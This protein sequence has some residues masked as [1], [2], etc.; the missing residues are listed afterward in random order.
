MATQQHP[1][2][3]PESALLN[4]SLLREGSRRKQQFVLEPVYDWALQVNQLRAHAHLEAESWKITE[5]ET[6]RSLQPKLEKARESMEERCRRLSSAAPTGNLRGDAKALVD[7]SEIVRES[8]QTVKQVLCDADEFPTVE[9][10]GW[11]RQPRAYAAVAS[12]LR[13]VNYE[14]DERSFEQYITAIQE[15]AVFE[16]AELWHLRPFAELVLLERAAEVAD[17]MDARTM[18]SVEGDLEAQPAT[19]AASMTTL[20]TS[21]RRIAGTD[22]KEVF[23]RVNAIERILREDPCHVYARMDFES[24]DTYR[25][26]I[27]E[28]A[29]RSRASEEEIARKALEFSRQLHVEADERV[30]ERKS[31]IGYH[32]VGDGR[33]RLENEIGYRRTLTERT[34]SLIKRCPDFTYMLAIELVTFAVVAAALLGAG[35]G[36]SG[37]AIVALFFLP[38][39]ECGVA[40]VNQLVTALFPPRILP[41]LDF[42]D[43][44]PREFAA[45]VAVPTL[46]TSEEQ[47]KKAVRDLEIRF[48]ANRDS[49]LHFALLTDPPDSGQ[50]FDEKDSLAEQC[51]HLIQE[52]NERYAREARGS[53]YLFHRHRAYNESEGVWMGWERKRGKLLDF[54]KLLLGTADNFPIKT[55]NLSILPEIKYVIPVDLDTQLPRD[56]ARKL[57]GA[58]AHPLNR[59]VINRATNTVVDGYGILQPRVDIS[60]QSA[61]RSRLAAIFSADA[62]FDIYA[63]AVSDVYQDL[64]GEG[65][66]TGKGIYEVKTFQQVLEHRFPCNAILSHDMIEGAYARAGLVSD[67]EVVDDYP[68][69]MSAYS[70]RKHRWVRGDWQIVFWLLPRV[71]NFFGKMEHN[72]LSIISRWKILD[73][74]RRSMTE[75]ATFVMLL[76]GWLF[77]PG[78]ALYWTLTTL[79]VV[80]LPTYSPFVLTIA[81]AKRALFTPAFWKNLAT[82][83]AIAQANLSMRI[84]C[85]CHQSLVSVDAIIRAVVRMTVTHERLLEWETAA[86]AEARS[87]KRSPFE[88]YLEITPWLAFFVGLFLAVD[89]AEA[90]MPALPLLVLWGLSKPIVQWLNLPARM[91]EDRM[92]AKDEALLRLSALRTWRLFREFSTAEENWLVPDTVQEPASLIVHRISTT[93]L[94]LLMNSRLAATDLGFF[95]LPE[96]LADTEKTLDTIDRMPKLN[97]QM[98]NWYDTLTLE[99][100]KPRF[101]SS[102]DNGN[103]VCCLW[104][105]K[106]GCLGAVNERVFSPELWRGVTDYLDAIEESLRT[107]RLAHPLLSV[108]KELKQKVKALGTSLTNWSEALPALERDVVVLDKRLS[109]D[110][111]SSEAGWWAHELCLRITHL[112][113]LV[114]DFVPWL[115]PQFARHCQDRE[116]QNIIHSER[117]SLESLPRIC[118]ALDQKLGRVL[119]VEDSELESRSAFQLLRSA[120]ARTSSICGSTTKRLERLA[121]RAD[122]LAK[123]L[124]FASMYDAQKKALSI[125][126]DVEQQRLAPYFYDLLPSEARAGAFVAIAKGEIPQDTWLSLERRYTEYEGERAMLSWTGTMFEYLMPM[127]W[128][129]T[130]PNT[131]LDEATQAAVRCQ[132]K[133]ADSK[134][135]PWG[136]SEASCSKLNCDGHYHYEAFGVP[137][138]AMNREMSMDLVVSPYSAFLALMADT[139]TAVENIRRMKDLGWMGSYGFYEAADFTPSRVKARERFEIVRCW[140]AHHQGMSLMAV[141]NVLCNGSSQRRFHA[142]PMVAASERL[143]HEKAPRMSQL[144]LPMITDGQ[145]PVADPNEQQLTAETWAAAASK[146]KPAA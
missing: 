13:A 2:F 30:C 71:P 28:L 7:G 96:F 109:E 32:L 67:V 29:K 52:L 139:K 113:N 47:M 135:M 76:S 73:N 88:T 61:N 122:A 20:M 114:Y 14:F 56:S 94:G 59:A 22:W 46:L 25:N 9:N 58:M 69:H 111:R 143:L 141:A 77:F 74:L 65:S 54:N 24:R 48:L 70:R 146:A 8:V 102:V 91:G 27:A 36:V 4:P 78:K 118:A 38:A 105:V 26:T 21:L 144:E 128:M 90:F 45:M 119:E 97:G 81:R 136:I 63:R 11:P 53:F 85:L 51:V 37:F 23:E 92:E 12:Y 120:L 112:E 107:E 140:L 34:R 16:M 80:A 133:Y 131:T 89:R 104:T 3:D 39:A 41:K 125:G 64:F 116:I 127:L 106:H 17:Q 142:E 33:K 35:V 101:V 18:E 75:T 145:P 138:L 100:V 44:I 86:E 137:A 5:R 43:G 115:A 50:Q 72:P 129:K 117:L 108:V 132:K 19:G 87:Q 84:A 95:T 60:I 82:D 42:S 123:N 68:S 10:S 83:F 49:N 98:Y 93:N 66:F 124:D 55:G 1:S 6:F 110:P 62:G 130:Y 15:I 121:N 126:F 40:L 134:S 99:P 31:H 103:L 79:A 57:V